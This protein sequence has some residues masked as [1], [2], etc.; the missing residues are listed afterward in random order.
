MSKYK[1]AF[2]FLDVYNVIGLKYISSISNNI[3][4][5]TALQNHLMKASADFHEL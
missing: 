4:C 1:R 2:Y 5:L 3:S